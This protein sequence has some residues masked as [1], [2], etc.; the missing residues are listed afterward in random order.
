MSPERITRFGT[1]LVVAGIAAGALSGN[2]M[3]AAKAIRAFNIAQIK[4]GWGALAAGAGAAAFALMEYFDIFDDGEKTLTDYQ[5][6]QIEL[7]KVQDELA[8]AQADS[9]EKLQNQLDLLNATSEVEKMRIQL[10]HEASGVEL[11]LI[12]AIVSKTE[13]LKAEKEKMNELERQRKEE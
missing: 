4:T 6:R 3:K 7:I 11:S 5:K 2:L 8:K 1:A 13:A 12:N 10:G 9:A